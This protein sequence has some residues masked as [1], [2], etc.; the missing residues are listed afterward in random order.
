MSKALKEIKEKSEI[1]D[2]FIVVLDGRIP[3]S[4]Y[5][6]EFDKIAPG[7]PRLFVITKIDL[8]DTNKLSRIVQKFENSNSKVILVN[9][10]KSNAKKVI[11]KAIADATKAKK[12]RDFKRGLIKSKVHAFVVGIPNS[13]KSTLIN[14]LASSKMKVANMPGVTRSQQW[15]TTGTNNDLF[16]LDTP[17]ILWPKFDNESIAVKIAIIGSIKQDIIEPMFL[18]NQGYKILSEYYPQI[19]IDLNLEP[20]QDET[21]IYNN[22]HK[23][24]KDKKM[25][26]NKNELDFSRAYKWF[27]NYLKDLKGV[28]YD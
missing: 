14:L 15:V 22:L 10:K 18:F 25:I 11:L 6:A 28:T 12:E 4:S 26:I 13:G 19:L 23:L 21:I 16:L 24:C 20:S 5:N 2:L 27:F 17:G 1:V 9:L 7:K 3:L 8:A